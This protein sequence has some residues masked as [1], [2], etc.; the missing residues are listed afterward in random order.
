MNYISIKTDSDIIN[1]YLIDN[2]MIKI[3][4]FMRQNARDDA[5]K[6]HWAVLEILDR[7]DTFEGS[8]FETLTDMSKE[9]HN[10]VRISPTPRQVIWFVCACDIIDDCLDVLRAAKER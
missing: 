10:Y 4:P 6:K 1:E 5:I 7:I 2:Y 8:V 3:K 9:F